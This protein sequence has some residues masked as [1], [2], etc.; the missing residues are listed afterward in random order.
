[1]STAER[2]RA[3]MPPGPELPAARR[4]LA[5]MASTWVGSS[6]IRRLAKASTAAFRAGVRAP[7]KKVRPRPT[8]P[9][10]V[11]SSRVTN[12]RVSVGSGSPTTSGL[13]A[14]VRRTRVV[15]WVIFIGEASLGAAGSE[16]EE[17][18]ER[19]E[20]RVGIVLVQRVDGAGNL[21]EAPLR[22][23]T[24]H[25]LG[26]VTIEDRARLAP[27]HQGGRGDRAD[28]APPVEIGLGAPLL[29]AGMPL[30]HEGAVGTCAET[31]RGDPAIVV[32]ARI[33]IAAVEMLGGLFDALPRLGLGRPC[34]SL[35]RPLADL[36]PDVDDHQFLDAV[37]PLRS[38]VHAVAP[39]HGQPHED[40]GRQPKLIDHA[41]DVVER[42]DGVVD[43]GGIAVA[44][45]A[46]IHR[47]DVEVRLERDAER[48]PGMRVPRE[49]M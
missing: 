11:P 47:V 9:W 22:E 6:P 45:A 8:S 19:G 15:T 27:Q 12:S 35:R 21:D 17:V 40:E 23:L 32:D 39:A 41:R 31:R 16:G 14:G 26:H 44:V 48:V 36:G 42:G 10:S 24:P 34:R 1:M 7:P 20:H 37:R 25:A 28:D 46:L 2:A 43:V 38:E 29:D 13:S 30:P 33:R 5:T 4:I 49:A 18:L 3:K